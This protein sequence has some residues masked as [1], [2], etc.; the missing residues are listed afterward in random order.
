[1]NSA[2]RVDLE[3]MPPKRG[4]YKE[5]FEVLF[6]REVNIFGGEILAW[7]GELVL[8]EPVT[9]LERGAILEVRDTYGVFTL[10]CQ[11]VRKHRV[12]I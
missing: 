4:V 8:D 2:K 10:T 6:G 9:F 1:M 5:L 11:L 7:L 3:N 12:C